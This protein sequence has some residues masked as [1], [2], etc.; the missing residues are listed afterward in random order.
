[1]RKIVN[2]Y[3]N[4]KPST[5]AIILL[6]LIPFIMFLIRGFEL[7]N[8]FWFLINTGKEI[9]KEGFIRIEPFTIHSGLFFISQQ[10]LTDIIFLLIYDSLGINGMYYLVLLCNGII[11]FLLYKL[12]YLVSNNRKRA[13]LITIFSD[14]FLIFSGILTTR[15]QLFDIIVFTLELYL[16]ELFINKNKTK[17]LY[18]IPLLSILLINY[19]SSMWPML[20]VLLV[21]YYVEAFIK[22]K[23]IIKDLFIVTVISLLCGFINPY[24]LDS[25][26]Y[27]FNSYG[28]SKINDAV[29]E[30]NAVSMESIIGKIVFIIIFIIFYSFYYNKK[31]NKIR[32]F[33][34]SM[35]LIYLSLNHYKA[36]LFLGI[37]MPLILGYNFKKKTI[38]KDIEINLFDKIV[39]LIG[40]VGLSIIIIV[41]TPLSDGVI[42]KEF[43]NYLDKN[44]SYDIKL[45]TDYNNGSYMEYR[46]YKCYIDPRAEVFVKANN[47]T[48]DIFDEYYDLLIGEIDVEAFLNKYQFDYLLVDKRSKYLLNELKKNYKYREVLSKEI[49]KDDIIYLYK[50]VE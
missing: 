21:P 45:Y 49:N 28:I 11:V 19:H 27:L 2:N 29:L 17:Y 41:K 16:I 7:D 5:Y 40:I 50:K 38:D 34:L 36:I 46:G 15:P 44:A 14:I 9:I 12:S 1:M 8:D 13:V 37:I 22:K 43:A 47:H 39:Y 26:K 25:I 30:M 48:F 42:I 10:W 6:L 23:Y 33:L 35:G 24:G 32:Y 20:F 3:K 4:W 18:F 31:N